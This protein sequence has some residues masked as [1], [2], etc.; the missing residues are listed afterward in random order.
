VVRRE[1]DVRALDPVASRAQ[2]PRIVL[3]QSKR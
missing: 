3:M 1:Q 2:K